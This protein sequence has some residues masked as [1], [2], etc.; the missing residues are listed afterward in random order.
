MIQT[1]Q[2]KQQQQQSSCD[3]TLMNKSERYKAFIRDMQ[4][5]MQL[6]TSSSGDGRNNKSFSSPITTIDQ[7]QQ[8]ICVKVKQP[9]FKG[10]GKFVCFVLRKISITLSIVIFIVI[11]LSS[12]HR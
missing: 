4:N 3:S 1:E 12:N 6:Q 10:T 7:Q 5:E 11:R 9:R 2:P 8:T